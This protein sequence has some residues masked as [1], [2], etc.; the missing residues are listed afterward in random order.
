MKNSILLLLLFSLQVGSIFAQ[1]KPL[2]GSPP[3]ARL[4]DGSIASIPKPGSLRHNSIG[5]SVGALH[6][7]T[8]DHQ[9]SPLT[10]YFNVPQATVFWRKQ[11]RKNLI[12]ISVFAGFGKGSQKNIDQ[13]TYTLP[14]FEDI[15][16]V[17]TI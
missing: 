1:T 5:L 6:Y 12:E 17:L 8:V 4:P 13:R 16:L 9:M 10:Y 11:K 14:K 15:L 7:R 3:Q 2:N